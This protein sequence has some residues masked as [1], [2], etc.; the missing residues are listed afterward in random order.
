MAKK[1][2]LDKLDGIKERKDK[3]VSRL[4]MKKLEDCWSLKEVIRI[5]R[6]DATEDEEMS[7]SSYWFMKD[8]FE[9]YNVLQRTSGEELPLELGDQA[10]VAF[11]WHQLYTW[12]EKELLKIRERPTIDWDHSQRS[13]HCWML[14]YYACRWSE[15]RF[16]D[17]DS[18]SISGLSSML[19]NLDS[20]FRK[21][22]DLIPWEEGLEPQTRCIRRVILLFRKVNTTNPKLSLPPGWSDS[23]DPVSLYCERDDE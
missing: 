11:A 13:A 3:L 4:F 6:P 21:H 9:I 15:G 8:S 22:Q 18:T 1:I 19:E 23:N 17:L 14:L 16:E 2:K 12:C 20:L 10:V 5:V 7:C